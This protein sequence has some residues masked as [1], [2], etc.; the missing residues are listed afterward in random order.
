MRTERLEVRLDPETRG[1]LEEVAAARGSSVSE[2]VRSLIEHSYE[3]EIAGAARL[4][5]AE[6]IG[7][8]E[9]EDVPEPAELKRQLSEAHGPGDSKQR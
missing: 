2:L 5:A 1:K 6:R 4:K 8:M 3:V 9:V 7:R